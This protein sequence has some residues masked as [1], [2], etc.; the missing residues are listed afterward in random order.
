LLSQKARKSASSLTFSFASAVTRHSNV[1]SSSFFA[2]EKGPLLIERQHL[3]D[4]QGN[5]RRIR[6]DCVP[7]ALV[8]SCEQ[9]KK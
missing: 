9:L 8:D 3:E 5:L 2:A 4:S 7:P 6:V 1:S